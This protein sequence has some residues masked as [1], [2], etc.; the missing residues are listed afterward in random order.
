MNFLFSKMFKKK[1]K[2]IPTKWH[3]S[4]LENGAYKSW[5]SYINQRFMTDKGLFFV[6][7][8]INPP[9]CPQIRPIE[10]FWACLKQKVYANNWSAS[11]RDVVLIDVRIS[12]FVSSIFQKWPMS[13]WRNL[14]FFFNIFENKKIMFYAFS[15]E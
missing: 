13:F 4:F 2:K 7:K 9:S 1:E 12:A 15:Q 11:T 6:P 10:Q 3:G 5:N 8:E 14:F